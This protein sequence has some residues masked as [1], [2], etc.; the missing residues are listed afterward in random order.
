VLDQ[1]YD[2]SNTPILIGAI[3]QSAGGSWQLRVTDLSP[4]HTGQLLRWRLVLALQ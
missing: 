1:R 4:G 2:L 3:G